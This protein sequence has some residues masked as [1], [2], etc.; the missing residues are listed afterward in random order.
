MNCGGAWAGLDCNAE[1]MLLRDLFVNNGI[2]HITIAHIRTT[3]DIL[4]QKVS[5]VG[6]YCT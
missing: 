4:K 5:Q 3:L 6:I 2:I 1:Y